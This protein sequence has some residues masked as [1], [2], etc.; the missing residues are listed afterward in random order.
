MISQI[1]PFVLTVMFLPSLSFAALAE[2]AIAL[3]QQDHSGTD[4]AHIKF[5]IDHLVDASTDPKV[6]LAE[7]DRMV[8]DLQKI[9]PPGA[10]AWTNVDALRRFVYVAGPWNDNRP[11]A[12]DHD[13]PYGK[14]ITNKLLSDYLA[15]R[16]GNCITMPILFTILGQR[17]GLDMTLAAAPSHF[18]VKFTDDTGHIWNLE[19]TSGAGRARDQHYRDLMP[20]SDLSLSSGIYLQPLT[21]EETIAVMA[22]L[23]V[24][25]LIADGR[26][27]D[28]MRVADAILK[29]YPLSVHAMIQKGSASYLLLKAECHE[30]YLSPAEVP[31]SLRQRLAL[32]QSVNQTIFNQAE[33]LGWQPFTPK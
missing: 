11:F 23:A 14:D 15:D 33:A 18:L 22:D 28:A 20:I 13:D 10:D 29:R 1:F 19:A 16:R 3:L 4:L 32:L 8:A 17:L 24:E 5:Q 2:E 9:I 12:Y 30:I 7:I 25:K 31:E 6:G 26:N 21:H 27:D